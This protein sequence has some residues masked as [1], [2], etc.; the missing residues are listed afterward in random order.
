MTSEVRGW[1]G[2]LGHQNGGQNQHAQ[3]FKVFEAVSIGFFIP[4]QSG[5]LTLP[6]ILDQICAKHVNQP[7]GSDM[8]DGALLSFSDF[9]DV[10]TIEEGRRP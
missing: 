1:H 10:R 2:L 7:L 5:L 8:A 4:F 3:S 9:C 6:S